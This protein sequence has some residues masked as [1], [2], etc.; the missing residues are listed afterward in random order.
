MARFIL[1]P[2]TRR[3]FLAQAGMGLLVL[4][5]GCPDDGSKEPDPDTG[6]AGDTGDSEIDSGTGGET[7]GETGDTDTGG[8]GETGDT[9]GV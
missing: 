4:A 6:G 3:A 5:A 9:A 1:A 8:A 7:G 2:N